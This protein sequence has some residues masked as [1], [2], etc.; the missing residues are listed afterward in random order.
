MDLRLVFDCVTLPRNLHTHSFGVRPAYLHTARL[1]CCGICI[2]LLGV[3]GLGFRRRV[4]RWTLPLLGFILSGLHTVYS[5]GAAWIFSWT[6][7]YHVIVFQTVSR[8]ALLWRWTLL[9]SFKPWDSSFQVVMFC[10]PDF[11]PVA[12]V[13]SLSTLFHSSTDAYP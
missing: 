6:C 1:V 5:Y 3:L 9:N 13:N 8:I 11:L 12:G 4:S 7:M 10:A 2:L